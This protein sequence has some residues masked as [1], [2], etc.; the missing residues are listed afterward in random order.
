MD[1]ITGLPLS[2]GCTDLL[3]ITDRLSK[4]VILEPCSSLTAEAVAETFIRVFYRHHGLPKAIVSDRGPQFTGALWARVCQLLKIIRRLSTA[5]SPETDGSTERMNQNVEAFVRTYVDY[6]QENWASLMPLA[7]LAINNHDAASTGVSPFF[8][9]HGYHVHPVELDDVEVPVR[10]RISPIQRG[11]AI[12]R[13]LRDACEWAQA[14]M[15]VA[16]Q[17]QEDVTNRTRQQAPSF[18]VGDKVWLNLE[19]VRTKRPSKKFDSKNAKYEVIEVI[20]SHSYRLNTPPGVRN[21]FHSRLL[22]PVATDPLPSQRTTDS[23]P[24]PELVDGSEEYGVEKILGK[25]VVRRGRGHQRQVLVKWTGYA[26]PTWEPESAF[27]DVTALDAYESL[28]REREGE[29]GVM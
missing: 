6:A 12:V 16:Q 1:F 26:D 10:E 7:E 29:G 9:T 8:L 17:V 23:Q 24:E 14:S 22:R 5:F 27:Q 20:G 2:Q 28:S 4:G 11:E 3:V 15:A 25:R 13:K 18:K 21:V 19:N